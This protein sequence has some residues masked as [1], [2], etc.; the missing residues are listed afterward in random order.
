MT[1]ICL[2]LF[3][4]CS[5]KIFLIHPG[6]LNSW[7]FKK[8]FWI[9]TDPPNFRGVRTETHLNPAHIETDSVQFSSHIHHPAAV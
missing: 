9:I 1:I 8:A 2:P 7:K 4:K 5:F 3:H 6:A